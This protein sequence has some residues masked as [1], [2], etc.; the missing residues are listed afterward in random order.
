MEKEKYGPQKRYDAKNTK[1]FA[2]K[3]NYKTDSDI[4]EFLDACGN[5]Q[6][7]IKEAL[8]AYMTK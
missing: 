5:K 8:R 4:I 7:A 2:F 3:L 1:Q 6:G